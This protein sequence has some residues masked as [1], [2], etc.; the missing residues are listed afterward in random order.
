MCA[1]TAVLP[2]YCWGNSFRGELGDG[3]STDDSATPVVVLNIGGA[4]GIALGAEHSCVPG[5]NAHCWG[6]NTS[7]QLCDGTTMKR[8]MQ[9]TSMLSSTTSVVAGNYF[10]CGL[11][12]GAAYCCGANADGELGIAPGADQS[13]P[14]QIAGANVASLS[15]GTNHG[16]L[17]TT[18]NQIS[19]WGQ[20][21]QGQ[22]GTGATSGPIGL[23]PIDTST[24][25]GA[26]FSKVVAGNNRTCAVDTT[27]NLWCWGHNGDGR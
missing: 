16:C 3:G 19:C 13:T 15:A 21:A 26:T 23:T 12:S 9:V 18:T 11:A 17:V 8:P 1:T 25:G 6:D 7:R 2:V 22:C 24:T 4:A 10:T 20:N 5:L 27:G 14:V